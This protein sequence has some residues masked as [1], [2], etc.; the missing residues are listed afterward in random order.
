MKKAFTLETSCTQ[1]L[2]GNETFG[3]FKFYFLFLATCD[4]GHYL[5]SKDQQCTPCMK[6]FFKQS[7]GNQSCTAC[8][9]NGTTSVT[10]STSISNCSIGNMKYKIF[11]FELHV[12]RSKCVPCCPFITFPS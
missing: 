10:G 7:N 9:E 12:I 8:P 5:N 3:F 2:I 6:G 4:P 1:M 11:D